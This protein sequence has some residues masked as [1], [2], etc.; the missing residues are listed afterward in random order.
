MNG[1][2]VS[3]ISRFLLLL[4]VISFL[5]SDRGYY[6]GVISFRS[7]HRFIVSKIAIWQRHT[8]FNIID[9]YYSTDLDAIGKPQ[10]GLFLGNLAWL[11]SY[12]ECTK[13]IENAHYC[14]AAVA[15]PVI[16]IT[17]VSHGIQTAC[18]F[19]H[20]MTLKLN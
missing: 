8:D 14:L 12:S 1:L 11:G 3:R 17:E 4:S 15:V 2:T 20:F 10:S 18:H 6:I 5:A 13:S 7:L 9:C 16:N 19:R